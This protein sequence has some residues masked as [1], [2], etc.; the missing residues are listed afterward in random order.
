MAVVTAE[1]PRAQLIRRA[2]KLAWGGIAWHAVEFAVALGAG[3]A[4][5]SIAAVSPA[6]KRSNGDG[7]YIYNMSV[8]NMTLNTDYTL[9][10]YPFGLGS[11]SQYLAHVIQTT[12]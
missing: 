12:K 8:A 10:V 11:P 4:A 2:R 3:I 9:L 7:S 6:M 1:L 5:G